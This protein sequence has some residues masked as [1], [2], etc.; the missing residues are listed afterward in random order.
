MIELKIY[1]AIVFFCFTLYG[2]V[3]LALSLTRMVEKSIDNKQRVCRKHD[4]TFS[5]GGYTTKVGFSF[6]GDGGKIESYEVL[7]GELIKDKHGKV[8]ARG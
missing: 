3:S 6:V 7:K 8:I 4:N 5:S 2:V 1:E